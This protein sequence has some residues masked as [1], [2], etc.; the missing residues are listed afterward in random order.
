MINENLGRDSVDMYL[1]NVAEAVNRSVFLNPNATYYL[2][3]LADN[4]AGVKKAMDSIM[5]F[6]QR[7]S[8]GLASPRGRASLQR[9]SPSV[10]LEA[11]S[12]LRRE[13]VTLTRKTTEESTATLRKVDDVRQQ[14]ENT[15]LSRKTNIDGKL[16]DLLSYLEEALADLA[17]RIKT[18]AQTELEHFEDIKLRVSLIPPLLDEIKDILREIKGDTE[19]ILVLA[20]NIEASL[21]TIKT[22]IDNI[23][24]MTSSVKEFT[25]QFPNTYGEKIEKTETLIS[26]LMAVPNGAEYARIVSKAGVARLLLRQDTLEALVAVEVIPVETKILAGVKIIVALL[27]GKAIDPRKIKPSL[28]DFRKQVKQAI[29]EW[30]AENKNDFLL[31]EKKL[32]KIISSWYTENKEEINTETSEFICD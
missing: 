3:F 6:R 1:E 28:D 12:S 27:A 4:D 22:E 15:V 23:E 31:D 21:Q 8:L 19:R 7:A 5:A 9:I 14:V 26:D 20:T 2:N 11:E 24:V 32:K 13:Q 30:Y 17:L 29:D 18:L 25:N 16:D 10:S